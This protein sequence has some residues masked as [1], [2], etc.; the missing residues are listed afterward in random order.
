MRIL[1]LAVLGVVALASGAAH[2]APN[3]A[4]LAVALA[5]APDPVAED[6]TLTYTVTVTNAGPRDAT[7]TLLTLD[8]PQGTSFVAA[9]GTGWS[10]SEAALVVTC[11]RPSVGVG[12]VHT[13]TVDVTPLVAGSLTASA[14][15][16]SFTSDPG[17]ADNTAT[18]TTTVTPVNDVPDAN[19]DTAT[20]P[21]DAAATAIAVLDNDTI[22]PDTGET[23]TI[24]AVTQGTSGDVAITGGGT[25][26]TY[27]PD[28][29]FHGDDAFTY[30]V[31]DGN[32]GF[33]TTTVD[34][35]VSPVQDA[36]VALDDVAVTP[37]GTPVDIAV[38]AN[39]QDVDGDVL[40]VTA[41]TAATSGT[42]V[43]IA[44]GMIR[45]TPGAGFFG[46]ASFSYTLSDGQGGEDTAT[47]TVTVGTDSDGDGLEDSVEAARGTDPDDDDT[48]NDGVGDGTEVG[49]GLDASNPDTDGDGIA[50][51]TEL[52]LTSP[53]GNDTDLGEFVADADPD[54]FTDP[55]DPDTD[56]GGARDG[57]E[58]RNHDGE[59]DAGETDPNDPDDDVVTAEDRDD[60]G[61]ADDLDVC[62]DDPDPDQ[63][64][65]DDDGLG[66]ACDADADG[67]GFADDLGVRGGG[68]SGG[69]GG[70]AGLILVLALAAGGLARRRPGLVALIAVLGVAAPARAQDAE[71]DA[72]FSI[73]RMRQSLDRDG[74]IAAEWAGIPEHGTWQFGLW[75]G[76]SDDPLVVYRMDERVGSLVHRRVG[77]SLTAAL[78]LFD[79]LEVGLDAGLVLDQRRDGMIET[80]ELPALAAYG[81]G[82][83]TVS[84]KG[85]IVPGV[86]VLA[87]VTIPA[88]S[89]GD[90]LRSY[91]PG[92]AAD[93]VLSRAFGGLRLTGNLGY[94]VRDRV[95]L[96][97]LV[98]DDEV[99]ARLGVGYRFRDVDP[100]AVPV[101]LAVALTTSVRDE[102]TAA[103]EVL[104]QVGYDLGL[105]QGY[106]GGGVGLGSGFGTPDWRFLVGLRYTV[107]PYRGPNYAS[108]SSDDD[109]I[110][111]VPEPEPEPEPDL[112]PADPDPDDDQIHAPHDRCP[113]EAEVVN[114]YADG[115]GCPD[116]GDTDRD[117]NLDD[118][119]LCP[120]EA[121][122]LDGLDDED[123]CLDPDDPDRD[124]DGLLDRQDNCPDVAGT[125]AQRGCTTKQ[126]VALGSGS[127]ALLETVAFVKNKPTVQKSSHALLDDLAALLLAHAEL[128]T[129]RIEVHTKE[130]GDLA[131]RRA[132]ALKWYLVDHGVQ[133]SRLTAVGHAQSDPGVMIRLDAAE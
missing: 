1:L 31:S 132:D 95:E 91:G 84:A 46:V 21:E 40:G 105:L 20:V 33:D 52:A 22:A 75:M 88:G 114:G 36:P 89:G 124:G 30:T 41:V 82:E 56:A 38:V 125:G 48:D 77:G 4:D 2:A 99:Q 123:G 116:V 37:G 80:T 24:T 73:E 25:G 94:R 126:R 13:V 71:E 96:L 6:A 87:A 74:V 3:R 60:D 61:V 23:L 68:C 51:G 11:S 42:A 98:V 79:R 19:G 106:A 121:E 118:V 128:A 35:T 54:T 107:E 59:V 86:A 72:R 17:T 97:D 28:P 76:A 5:D 63:G 130:R 131:Q 93:L 119:D 115:D 15:V 112:P 44:G 43:I 65:A 69:G 26:V 90:Y 12:A 8:L 108:R 47:V 81:L 62:P 58:D 34:V 127:I 78:A 29:D 7:T 16:D 101:E 64:D 100:A 109:L 49:F 113:S 66:D 110:V 50:D 70:G 92:V 57:N 111:E 83:L 117:G 32:G 10:C 122:D 39:D 102:A 103:T 45:Y 53:E 14:T 55:D 27:Q 85:G 18:T 9:A 129:V 120:E 67:D 133:A 104:G